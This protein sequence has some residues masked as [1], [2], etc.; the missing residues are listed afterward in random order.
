[1]E[2]IFPSSV[3]YRPG[4]V[5]WYCLNLVCHGIFQFLLVLLAILIWTGIC[6]FLV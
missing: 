4:F 1:L 3:F 5:D 2:W 6:G